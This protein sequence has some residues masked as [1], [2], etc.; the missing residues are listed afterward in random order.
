[1]KPDDNNGDGLPAFVGMTV[2]E[3]ATESLSSDCLAKK[4][5]LAAIAAVI[6]EFVKT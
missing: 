2:I 3:K 1:L 6:Y 4:N 5:H